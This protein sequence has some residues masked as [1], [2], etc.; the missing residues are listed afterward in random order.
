MT[1]ILLFAGK[2]TVNL[3]PLQAEEN[4][5]A[6][7][8]YTVSIYHQGQLAGT[9]TVSA[10]ARENSGLTGTFD[11]LESAS[12]YTIKVSATS[13]VGQSDTTVKTAVTTAA[14]AENPDDNKK[15]EDNQKPDNGLT[16]ED[17]KKSDNDPGSDDNQKSD[18]DQN[19]DNNKKND[20]QN[21]DDNK[22]T[23]DDQNSD[24]NKKSDDSQNPSKDQT[25]KKNNT[26]E[27][28]TAPKTADNTNPALLFLLLMLSG[29]TA[30]G[31]T[32]LKKR[33]EK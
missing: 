22:K 11:G 32:F 27:T 3:T 4:C 10:N 15:P 20:D 13:P 26:T 25:A 31:S 24:D 9:Q 18:D 2:V 17:D 12:D 29:V 33:R 19:N 23:D 5:P 16:S 6:P 30:L 1:G 14:D 7:D 8:F 21:N 28:A